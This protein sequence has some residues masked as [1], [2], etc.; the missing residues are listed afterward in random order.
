M[1]KSAAPRHRCAPRAQL[2]AA[3]QTVLLSAATSY[4]DVVRDTAILAC[5]QHNV[6]VLQKQA[7]ATRRS[8]TPV[9]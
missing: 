5:A 8:S 6:E 3:E 1:R 7:D 4:M 2:L 9:R